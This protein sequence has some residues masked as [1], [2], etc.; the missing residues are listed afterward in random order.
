MNKF[1]KFT[2]KISLFILLIFIVFGIL[3][4]IWVGVFNPSNVTRPPGI[5]TLLSIFI[6]WIL[7]YRVKVLEKIRDKFKK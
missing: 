3:M 5:I 6:S 1:L 7:I 4:S 2:I